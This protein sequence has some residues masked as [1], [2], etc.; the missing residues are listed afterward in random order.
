VSIFKCIAVISL[1]YY[2][3]VAVLS[4]I[5][6]LPLCLL[7]LNL[8]KLA[9][10]PPCKFKTI[11]NSQWKSI[12]ISIHICSHSFIW[13]FKKSPHVEHILRGYWLFLIKWLCMTVDT[14]SMCFKTLFRRRFP[15]WH[16]SWE[17]SNFIR[18]CCIVSVKE[19][20]DPFSQ[21]KII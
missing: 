7:N 15:S 19:F 17:I 2:Y 1:A 16:F 8:W 3:F 4:E 18:E 12:T 5:I 13:L 21:T 9:C 11:T 20:T 14:V 10:C 6:N